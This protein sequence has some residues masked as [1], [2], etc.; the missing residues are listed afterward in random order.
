MCKY[1]KII[2]DYVLKEDDILESLG[3][4]LFVLNGQEKTL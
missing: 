4:G 1:F 3:W 2:L